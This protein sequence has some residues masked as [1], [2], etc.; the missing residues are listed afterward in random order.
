MQDLST[1]DYKDFKDTI[2]D[3]L[4]KHAPLKRKY[5][6][7]NHSNFITKELS[8]A[9]MQR[10]KL[11][12]LYLKVRS[13]ENRIRYKKQRNICVSLLRKAKRKHFE[14]LS[15]ADVTDNKKFWKRVKPLFGNK[16]KGNPNIALVESNDLITDEKS[17]AE[18]FNNYFVNVVSNL[19]IN[20]L[21]NKSGKG[22]V[23]NYYNH[24]SITTIKQHITDKN[25]VFSFRKVTKDEISSVIKTLNHKKATLSNDIPTKIIQQ[26]SDIF[27]DFLYNNFNSCLE[28]GIFPDE[29]KLAEVIPVY[30][31]ND[32]KDK[33][34]Y[35]PISILSNISKIYER[36][37]QTQL[38]EYFAKFLSKFQCGF[39]KGFS[40][41]HCL[42]VMIE[43]LRKIRDEKGVFAAVLTDLSKAFDCIPHQLLIAKLSA[44][45]FDTKSIAFISA[46]LKNRKQKTKIGSTF[47]ECLNILFGV[48]QGSILGPL[49]FLIFIAD[50]FYLNYD[51]DFAS[52]ADDTTPYICGQDF[53]SII[54]V[55]EPNVNTHFNWFRQN[56]LIANSSKSHFLTSPYERRTLKIHDSIITSSSSE[57]LLGILI[58]SELTFHDHITRLCSKANQKLSALARVSKYM[59]LP[60]RRLLMSSYITSHFNYCPLVWMIHNRKL[61]KKISKV[62]ERAL[63]IV[64]GD[65]KTS[66]L[67][68]LNIDKSVTIHQRNLQYL[69]IE[70]YK[71]KKGISPTIMNEIFQFFENPVYELRSGVHLPGRN[72]RTVFFGTESIINLGAK[73]WNVVPENIKS[74]ESLNVFKSKIKHWSPNHCPCRICKT[75]IGQIGFIN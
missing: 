66:F 8:K 1:M 23:S 67:E 65:H 22:D 16:I 31:K 6:R 71:V 46:Y 41:Q 44:Y 59:T 54:N 14:D 11:R 30:K 20:I 12:N 69:L 60:K 19:G 15:I 50:L 34:N 45:G 47:S 10:S 72:S 53:S 28:S 64:H 13:D 70:I 35:R 73:L 68:L 55:L 32:K 18:T 43:K 56:G 49:L 48:P 37:I 26:F 61:N 27:T 62:H 57:E 75:Y 29:L 39:R 42:L 3:S 33:S 24:P 52:Y 2:I 51:L 25:K 4:N 74:S 63:R 7:A 36:C 38:N 21:D 17:L 9:I 58:D 40:T 5:L